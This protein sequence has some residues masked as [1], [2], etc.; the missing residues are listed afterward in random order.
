[1]TKRLVLITIFSIILSAMVFAYIFR[2]PLLQFSAQKG[3]GTAAK[4]FLL[5]GADPQANNN[6]ALQSAFQ[7]GHTDIVESLIDHGVNI[8]TYAPMMLLRAINTGNA[9]LARLALDKSNYNL[10]CRNKLMQ[11]AEKSGHKDLIDVMHQRIRPKPSL[12]TTEDMA[13]SPAEAAAQAGDYATALTLYKKSADLGFAPAQ[14]DLGILYS[15]GLGTEQNPSEAFRL[16]T[17]SAEGNYPA[18]QYD[19]ATAYELGI[20]TDINYAEAFEN[21]KKAADGGYPKAYNGLGSLYLYGN[22]VTKN[23]ETA[24]QWFKKSAD[25]GDPEGEN[26]IGWM[27]FAGEGV[28]KNIAEA[29]NW[30]QKSADRGDATG[31]SQL[32]WIH[33][34]FPEF[35]DY[36]KAMK[37]FQLAQ[38][39]GN[40]AGD[41]NVGYLY[42][43]GLGVK[44][45]YAAAFQ[46]YQMG[47]SRGS[48]LSM[49]NMGRFYDQ[50]LGVPKDPDKAKMLMKAASDLGNRDAQNWIQ[51]H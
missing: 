3:Y 6:E 19:L 43:N 14:N 20:G 33:T 2:T 10:V 18:G 30:Y 46:A 4:A 32:G 24:M 36:A 25:I 16:F 50:G 49:F 26:S 41:N 45:D 13:P 42:E 11:M 5:M 8:N 35:Q 51:S 29:K 12:C 21:Y 39:Q 28:P 40:T 22:G 9:D 37:L 38:A 47:A 7:G 48:A 15:Q 31:Q 44:K 17:L 34:H 1:M 27:Y 23:P